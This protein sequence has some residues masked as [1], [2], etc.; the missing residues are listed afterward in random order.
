MVQFFVTAT[1]T[2]DHYFSLWYRIN[3]GSWVNIGQAIEQAAGYG[4]VG[5]QW[6]GAFTAV[7]GSYV[8]FGMSA[9]DTSLNYWNSGARDIRYGSI[10]VTAI[11][12]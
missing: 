1:V 12:F 4:T 7:A 6:S 11:N 10:T 5:L 8:E 3:G 9:T 2:V